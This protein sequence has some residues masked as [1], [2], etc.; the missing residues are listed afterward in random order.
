MKNKV[1]DVKPFIGSKDYELS[2]QFYLAMGWTLGFDTGEVAELQLGE[3][4]FILQKWYQ[5]E[6]CDNLML[7]IAVEDAQY[8]YEHAMQVL[9]GGSYDVA[10]VREPSKQDSGEFVTF[11][12]DPAG[13]LLHFAQP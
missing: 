9:K 12:W 8:W 1:L 3:Y 5:K 11:V 4:R 2:R 6:W 13:V 7:H 10:K